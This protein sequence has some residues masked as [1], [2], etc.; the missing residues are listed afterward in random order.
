MARTKTPRVHTPI[1]TEAA[2]VYLA[3]DFAGEE[4]RTQ[5][6]IVDA[7]ASTDARVAF[8]ESDR[9]LP[10]KPPHVPKNFPPAKF[11]AIV[12]G[13]RIAAPITTDDL[14]EI[15]ATVKAQVGAEP[16]DVVH[17]GGSVYV[18]LGRGPAAI[19]RAI[20]IR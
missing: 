13:I 16:V 2:R 5:A 8:S 7:L 19:T 4:V 1:T 18:S 11:Y 10:P 20:P 17:R 9:P 3:V 12:D 15:H 14:K 6:A